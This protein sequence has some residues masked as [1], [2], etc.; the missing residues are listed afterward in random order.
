M[1]IFSH[2]SRPFRIMNIEH[3]DC[4][5]KHQ[6]VILTNKVDDYKDDKS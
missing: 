3:T 4:V 5:V 1:G 2:K 6:E